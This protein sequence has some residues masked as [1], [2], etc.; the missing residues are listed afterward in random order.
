M[1][2]TPRA[3]VALEDAALGECPH[4][5]EVDAVVDAE[6]NGCVIHL[7][8]GHRLSVQRDRLERVGQVVLALGVLRRDVRERAPQRAGLERVDPGVDLG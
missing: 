6:G 5:A 3:H 2:V 8:R 1:T 4:P 7:E